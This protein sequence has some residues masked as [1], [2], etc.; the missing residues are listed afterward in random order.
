[1][2]A[3]RQLGLPGLALKGYARFSTKTPTLF[4]KPEAQ[5][6]N[7]ERGPWRVALNP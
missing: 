1:M 5:R 4:K 3:E 7:G 6:M 2:L